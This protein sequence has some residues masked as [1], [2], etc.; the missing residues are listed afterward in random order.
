M[1]SGSNRIE[2]ISIS[3]PATSSSS[4]AWLIYI[5]SIYIEMKMACL[6][7]EI[8]MQTHIMLPHHFV[9]T[10]VAYLK[11][12]LIAL[13]PCNYQVRITTDVL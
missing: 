1:Q 2:M 13:A 11:W 8:G 5:L 12:I 10:T 4:A 9:S 6:D 7:M 3:S